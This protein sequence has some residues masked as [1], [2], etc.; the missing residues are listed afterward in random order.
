MVEHW[1]DTDDHISTQTFY[2]NVTNN[3]TNIRKPIFKMF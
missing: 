1:D 3:H 2:V